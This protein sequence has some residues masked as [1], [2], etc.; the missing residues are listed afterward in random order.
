[1]IVSSDEDAEAYRRER[2]HDFEARTASMRGRSP[3]KDLWLR[4]SDELTSEV[5]LSNGSSLA[6]EMSIWLPERQA[7]AIGLLCYQGTVTTVDLSGLGM[8][9]SVALALADMLRRNYTCTILNLERNDFRE[10]GL[11]A[12]V[13][14]LGVNATLLEL[15]LSQQKTAVPLRVEEML[16]VT[17]E[18][19]NTTLCKL[20]LVIRDTNSRIRVNKALFRN[21]DMQRQRRLAMSSRGIVASSLA[22]I[23][24]E[25]SFLTS[26]PP[27]QQS[28]SSARGRAATN[29]SSTRFKART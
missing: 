26:S 17:L 23:P 1:M 6:Q 25:V 13:E 18:E 20:G 22:N 28:H 27:A 10:A 4:V 29:A 11:V 15:R 16:S 9:D 19:G 5:I 2:L 12:I 3:L 7:A 21:T 8:Q 24:V 14:A